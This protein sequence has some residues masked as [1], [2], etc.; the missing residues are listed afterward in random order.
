VL[1]IGAICIAMQIFFSYERTVRVLKWLTLALFAY[2]AVVL[3]VS[4]PWAQAIAESLRPWAF[5]P[6]GA[7]GKDYAA[8]VVAVLGT[9]ISPYLFFWQATQEVE[10]CRRR[11]RAEPAPPPAYVRKHLRRIKLDTVVGMGFSNS[12]RSASSSPRRSP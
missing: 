8:M 7:S 3:V 4:V 5:L 6:A 9:T 10:D 1:A 2:V 11:P 12:W